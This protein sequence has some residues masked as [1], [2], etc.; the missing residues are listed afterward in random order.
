MCKY[1]EI[2]IYVQIHMWIYVHIFAYIYLYIYI[3]VYVYIIYIYINQYIYVCITRELRG[4]AGSTSG[5]SLVITISSCDVPQKRH[6]QTYTHT[7]THAQTYTH[8]HIHRSPVITISS[9]AAFQYASCVLPF[10]I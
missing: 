5:G 2:H 9:C 1:I 10:S 4:D 7:H 8:T 3:H 6:A